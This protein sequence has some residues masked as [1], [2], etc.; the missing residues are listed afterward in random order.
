MA[1]NKIGPDAHSTPLAHG[2]PA[3]D[4]ARASRTVFVVLT[5]SDELLEQ[6]GQLLDESVEVRHAEH[7]EEARQ[8]ADPRHAVVMLVDAREHADPSLTVERLHASDGT[9]VIVV[10]APADAVADV[11]RAIRGSAAFAVLPIPLETDKTRAVLMGAGEEAL[12][13]RALMTPVVEA[14][15]ARAAP[16]VPAVAP[17][18]AP[19]TADS[20]TPAKRELAVAAPPAEDAT[21]AAA[22]HARV[23]TVSAGG[24]TPGA[25]GV[26]RIALAIAAG[27]AIVAAAGWL[28]L[29]D[30]G[31]PSTAEVTTVRPTAPGADAPAPDAG[32]PQ[33]VSP[34]AA[35]AAS[36]PEQALSTDPTEE[37]L[38][39]ARVAFH[40]RRYTDP[41]GD[42]ALYYYRS[43][44]ARDPQDGEALQGLGR[45]GSVLD[46][47]LKSALAEQRT[48]DAA[49]TLEHLRLI[50]PDD[51]KL[52]ATEARLVESRVG[53]ALS[54][55]DLTAAA[56]LLRTA[57]ASGATA[58]RLAPLREQL[59]RL[60]SGQRVEQ[61]ARLVNARIRDGQL[62]APPGDSA[63]YHLGQLQRLP[64][65][66]RLAADAAGDLAR[67]MAE[68]GRQAQAQGQAS[69]AERWFAEARALGYT[70]ERPVAA[71]AAAA[72]AAA[73]EPALPA[74]AERPAGP[75]EE[76]VAASPPRS[77][78]PDPEAAAPVAEIRRPG[79][80][81][82]APA[83]TEVSAAD[84][85]RTRF[86]PPVYPPQALARGLEG[87][88][89][90]RITVDVE[91][92]VI[93]A[94]VLSSTPAAVFDQ[95]AVN[96]ARKWRFEP[97]VRDGSPIE[98]SVMTTIRFR[99][100]QA[101]R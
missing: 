22:T 56:A 29:R 44:L 20:G 77:E 8:F 18:S 57:Q 94:R 23:A 46:G 95:A 65:G 21:D 9:T 7:E 91:G 30:S 101:Q 100:D 73:P 40:E 87:D 47:R 98:A 84:F 4:P 82:A 88:V 86:V 96:A 43:V 26:P 16:P 71:V 13:R 33:E 1:A 31:E 25:R 75:R 63:K 59:A 5:G 78:S 41:D 32:V 90:L 45:I 37:L 19:P 14:A 28:Y 66:K 12:A 10:F 17:A 55:G 81:G 67:A 61:L 6:I 35:V 2:R 58:E 15:P 54:R 3:Q 79:A 52:V 36:R 34:P 89:R 92:R 70:P 11:A 99:P 97:V 62:L 24:S 60:E 53:A 85:K 74:P 83:A 42:N 27:V 93:D 50:R 76:T 39:R 49:R 72:P 64:N 80:G 68:R 51:P 69:E 38:D 48:D